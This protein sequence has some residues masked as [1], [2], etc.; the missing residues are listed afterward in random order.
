M[1]NETDLDKHLHL[2]LTSEH[3]E[4]EVYGAASF[5]VKRVIVS[6]SEYIE[7]QYH[8]MEIKSDNIASAKL[9]STGFDTRSKALTPE[10]IDALI[11]KGYQ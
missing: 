2:L 4:D 5:A 10:E 8:S 1:S 6:S 3:P 9:V 7:Y 11:E